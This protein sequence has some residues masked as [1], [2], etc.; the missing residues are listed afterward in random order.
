MQVF[1]GCSKGS[2]TAFLQETL[3]GNFDSRLISNGVSNSSFAQT[4]LGDRILFC[5]FIKQRFYFCITYL[6]EQMCQIANA[7]TVHRPSKFNLR[8]NL[9]AISNSNFA[10]VV[11]ETRH[12]EGTAFRKCNCGSHPACNIA[13]Y[14]AV[15]PVSNHDFTGYTESRTN[16]TILTITMSG[17]VRIHEIHVD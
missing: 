3:Q 2:K 15:F 5:I 16:M 17:L 7:V 4:C 1:K 12:L 10:H 9:I 14:F 8:L 6:I 13:S 11:S